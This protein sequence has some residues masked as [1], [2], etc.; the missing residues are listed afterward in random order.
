MEADIY[1]AFSPFVY[2]H[3][4][5]MGTLSYPL[6]NWIFNDIAVYGTRL[7]LNGREPTASD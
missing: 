2:T 7:R 3:V 5:I 4:L 1:A 6:N